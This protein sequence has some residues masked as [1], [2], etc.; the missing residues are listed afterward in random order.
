ML[1]LSCIITLFK[2]N[3]TDS[4]VRL[5]SA[6]NSGLVR[7]SEEQNL[8]I[9][10]DVVVLKISKHKRDRRRYPSFM[11]LSLQK[12]R[13]IGWY[14]DTLVPYLGRAIFYTQKE[15]KNHGL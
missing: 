10:V 8:K 1:V 9:T 3:E 7:P 12:G 13:E 6:E 4:K 11:S 5:S 14:H 2:H 15:E